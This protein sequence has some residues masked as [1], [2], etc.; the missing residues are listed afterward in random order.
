MMAPDASYIVIWNEAC[1]R[2]AERGLFSAAWPN[3]FFFEAP[4]RGPCTGPV[5]DDTGPR[6]E[7][8]PPSSPHRH[9][10]VGSVAL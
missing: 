4:L 2:Q 5:C 7:S 1:P 3:S 6:G 10:I 8:P 9:C